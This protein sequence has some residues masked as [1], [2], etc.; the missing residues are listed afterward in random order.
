MLSRK[1]R[2]LKNWPRTRKLEADR[3]KIWIAE[4]FDAPM[5]LVEERPKKER[6]KR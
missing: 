5:Y 2:V 1:H 4:D 6:K 3:G